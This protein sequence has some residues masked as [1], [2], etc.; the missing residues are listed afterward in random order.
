MAVAAIVASCVVAAFAVYLIM[1]RAD[2]TEVLGAPRGGI[3]TLILVPLAFAA[4]A[5]SYQLIK[6]A[7]LAAPGAQVRRVELPCPV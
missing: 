7:N 3:A 1:A 6:A 4:A 2:R 5:Y